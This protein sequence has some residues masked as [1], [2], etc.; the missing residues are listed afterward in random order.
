MANGW[1]PER[2]RKQSEAIRRWRPW[3][4]STGPK[5]AQGKVVASQN[6]FKHGGYSRQIHELHDL[7]S[8]LS[9][10]I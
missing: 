6:S 2:R 3:D 10:G 5:T 7:I 4:H 9:V 1:T 8:R